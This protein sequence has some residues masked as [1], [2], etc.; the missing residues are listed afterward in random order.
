MAPFYFAVAKI[1]IF[2]KNDNRIIEFI[3]IFLIERFAKIKI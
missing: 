1:D 2:F 3:A